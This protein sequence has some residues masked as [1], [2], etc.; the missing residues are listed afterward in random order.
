MRAPLTGRCAR[1]LLDNLFTDVHR[2]L[3]ELKDHKAFELMRH[4]AL[5]GLLREPGVRDLVA[6]S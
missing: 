1:D 5:D 4:D 3:D 2:N 6:I